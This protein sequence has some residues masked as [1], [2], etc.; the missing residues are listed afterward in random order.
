MPTKDEITRRL[1]IVATLARAQGIDSIVVIE[2]AHI[3]YLSGFRTTLY[4]RF[5]G[6]ALRTDTP[7]DA[8]LIATAVDKRLTEEPVWYPSRLERTEIYYRGAPAE[9]GLIADPGVLI[10]QVVHAGDTVGIDLHGASY[11]NVEMILGRHP[12][13]KL[14]DATP[15]L[16][17]ARSVKSPS[18]IAAMTLANQIAVDALGTVPSLL[19]TG[20]TERELG[21]ALDGAAKLA[22]SDGFAYP[23]LIGFG[24]KSLA[25]H[26]PPTARKL[27]RDEIVT[28]AYGPM[29]GGYCADIVRTFFFGTPPEQAV[30][31]G[32]RGVEIQAAALAQIRTGARAGDPANAAFDVVHGYYPNAPKT[33]NA[34]HSLG[35]TVHEEPSLLASND[36]PLETNMI[37]AIEPSAPA[38]AMEGIGLYRHCDVVRVTEAGYDLLTPLARGLV[39]VPLK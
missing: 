32:Q 15:V 38:H 18:E 30:R 29:A 31:S 26:A 16:H 14:R 28:I 39:V 27:A 5:M 24:P 11:G 9:S 3:F 33:T 2:P 12:D 20:I 4:T 21:A 22:G 1:T 19:R 36:Q 23:T 25:P 34:G 35:L 13:L 6:V 10:D 37:I 8:M 7:E 17:A